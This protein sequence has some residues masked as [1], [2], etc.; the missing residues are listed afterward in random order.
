MTTENRG[1]AIGRAIDSVIRF[2]LENKLVVILALAAIV[3]WGLMVMP[4]D[5]DSGWLPRD[6]VPV[7]AIPDIGENQ[8]IVFTEWMGRSPQDVEDQVTYPLTVSLLGVPG[9]KTIRSYSYLGF[10]SVYVVFEEKIEFYWARSRIL[11]RLSVAQT[12]LPEDVTPQLGPDATALGQIFWYT[13]EGRDVA[14]GEPTGGWDLDQLRS[15]Q[16]WYVR[17]ALQSAKGISEVASV[18]GFV[19]E[20]QV[21]VDPDAMR[22]HGVTLEEVFNAVRQSNLDVGA[23]TIEV[24][25]V[26]YVIRGLGF[27][28]QVSDL[29]NTVIKSN[30]NVPLYVKN[31]AHVTTGPL[32]AEAE[33]RI[34]R[35]RG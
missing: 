5:Y 1:D 30:E 27:L 8:Q 23:R 29:E 18:G 2:C 25:R 34:E 17:Y 19:R 9:V 35:L 28:K 20:Y 24:N 21:D 13:L 11:E 15:I 33:K 12:D 3:G 6:P 4:F 26:E 32:A 31:V 10:S 7:D 14:T 16:D 22:A